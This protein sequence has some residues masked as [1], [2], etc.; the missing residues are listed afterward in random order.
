MKEIG[1]FEPMAFALV[2]CKK[3]I[4]YMILAGMDFSNIMQPYIVFF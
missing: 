2:V 4:V 3:Q 1:V